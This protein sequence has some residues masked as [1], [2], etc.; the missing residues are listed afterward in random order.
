MSLLDSIE[1]PNGEIDSS[2]TA[3]AGP[4]VDLKR[5]LPDELR[6][7]LTS[8][9]KERYRANQLLRWIHERGVSDFSEMTNLSKEFR[10]ELPARAR[11]ERLPEI[12]RTTTDDG[13]TTKLLLG[14][15]DGRRVEAVAMHDGKRRT[16]C[17]SS[18]AGCALGCEFCATGQLGLLRQLSAGEIVDQLYRAADLFRAEGYT[19]RPVTNVV[20]MGMG[21]PL[22]NYD[23]VLRAI[24]L[25]G[26]EMGLAISAT[27][28]TI[29]TAGLVPMIRRVAVDMPKVGLAVSLNATT[30]EVRDRIMPVNRRWPL[31]ELLDAAREM[32]AATERRRVTLEYTLIDGVNDSD[33]DARRLAKIASTLP[34]KINLIPFNPVPERPFRRPAN[35]RIDRF[36]KILWDK[37]FTVTV[38]WSKGDDIAAAC[39]QLQAAQPEVP[40]ERVTLQGAD[41]S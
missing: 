35:G 36:Y 33:D 34:C 38:R 29:S 2:E 22:H 1:L 11:I 18:Q 8:H 20:F 9:G 4:L 7:F 13:S 39:G 14:L 24:R 6:D 23:E 15:G 26:L 37:H 32:A 3:P 10:A 40:R 5:L 19:D 41:G 28:V 30:D 17:V 31:S 12:A 25:I 21:E 27:K 16:V